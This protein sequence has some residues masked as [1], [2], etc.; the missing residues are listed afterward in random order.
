MREEP[1]KNWSDTVSATIVAL[2]LFGL[3]AAVLIILKKRSSSASVGDQPWPFYLKR[4]LSEPEQVLY[5]RLVQA[6]PECIVLAQVQLSR[7]LGV[8]KGA[9][10]GAWNNRI[11]QKSVDFVVCLKDSTVVAVVE[12]DDA[13]HARDSR[14]T[15]DA[16]KD[17][18]LKSAGV[19]I[20]RWDTKS[21]PNEETIRA[22]FTV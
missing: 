12:L 5:H 8:K 2:G 13:T 1:H 6:M 20:V 14:R 11:S 9:N 22:A 17:K 7:L 15:A 16:N 18:A 21:L 3:A 19:T 4:P 10:F